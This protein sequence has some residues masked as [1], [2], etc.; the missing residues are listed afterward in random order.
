M[1][2]TRR[3]GRRRR[4]Y[5]RASFSRRGLLAKAAKISLAVAGAGAGYLL[6]DGIDRFLATYNP[7]GDKTPTDKF[8]SDGAG[9]LAN[10]LNVA[11]PPD[12][13]RIGALAGMILVPAFASAYMPNRFAKA[14]LEGIAIGA[15]VKAFV[16]VWT[17]VIV[18]MLGPKKDADQAAL[19]G[20]VIARLYPAEVAAKIN[21]ENQQTQASASGAGAL[22][23]ATATDVGPFAG[24]GDSSPYP[25]TA[26][27][28]RR[29]AGLS[30]PTVANTWGTGSPLP[31]P[32]FGIGRPAPP[33]VNRWRYAHPAF[34]GYGAQ[35]NTMSRNWSGYRPAAP[36]PGGHHHHHCMARAK[37]MYP[38]YTD[39]QLHAWCHARPHHLYPYLYEQPV[40]AAPTTYGV[41]ADADAAAP[42]PDA[43]AAPPPAPAG[44]A[45]PAPLPG[46]PPYDSGPPAYTPGPGSTVGPGPG[47]GKQTD[48]ACLGDGDQFLGF[49][50]DAEQEK[51][52]LFNTN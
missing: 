31:N 22:S 44:E 1:Q 32:A 50:G 18:P 16:T 36:L 21:L 30:Y 37:T 49:I 8:T 3:H 48:C 46:P 39:S 38:A 11:S 19:K 4:H 27:A 7:N 13:K 33:A 40:G 6:A 2:S 14:S 20:S 52:V 35:F 41:S 45:A 10:T 24:V 34:H 9:T 28:L 29:E 47:G 25:D 43:G 26:Q 15:G 51:D 42:P 23:G 17:N 5:A 12:L